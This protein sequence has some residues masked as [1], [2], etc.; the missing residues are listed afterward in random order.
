MYSEYWLN[1]C[2]MFRIFN[3]DRSIFSLSLRFR[4][5]EPPHVN[6]ECFPCANIMKKF[7]PLRHRQMK[8][9][10]LVS[11][12]R[13]HDGADREKN[14]NLHNL[15]ESLSISI[16]PS[17]APRDLLCLKPQ[18][19]WRKKLSQLFNSQ[20]CYSILK[21]ETFLYLFC[22]DS[23]AKENIF[24]DHLGAT[25]VRF[26]IP[27]AHW[28]TDFSVSYASVGWTVLILTDFASVR[29]KDSFLTK[30]FRFIT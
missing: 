9:Y 10:F 24:G 6:I 12:R 28:N 25:A 5:G 22:V 1:N 15:K 30:V 11:P 2:V 29:S 4:K 3:K 23:T 18:E 20:I 19:N 13:T 7:F 27:K 26:F 21:C 8:K 17:R 14:Q 16:H